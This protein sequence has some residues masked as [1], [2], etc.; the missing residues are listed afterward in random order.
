MLSIFSK[1]KKVLGLDITEEYIRYSLISVGSGSNKVLMCGE[2]KIARVEPRNAL[3]SAIRNIINK[4]K[5]KN[6]HVSFPSDFIHTE[7]VALQ[8]SQKEILPDIEL[9]LKEKNVFSFTDAIL[10]FEKFESV[11]KKDFYNVFISSRDNVSFLRSVFV[12][13]GLN[14]RKIVSH[15]DALLASCVKSGEIINTMVLNVEKLRT[16]IAIFSPFN[17][18]KAITSLSEDKTASLIKETYQDF[19]EISGDKIGYFF[20]SGS[21]AADTSFIN[22]LS[23]Q[24]RL[25]IQEADVFVNFEIA[26]NELPPVTRK[27]SF[28]YALALGTA[29][30]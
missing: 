7:T 1:N 30:S 28:I 2:E 22:S 20:I 21:L 8:S 24:T 9:R 13:S 23:R 17:R 4:T 15:K 18:F 29:L 14:V 19:Y 26:K 3:L 12:N 27:E 11:N 5:C 10:Y 16:D 6:A 25:P